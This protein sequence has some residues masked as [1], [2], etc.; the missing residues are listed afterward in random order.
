MTR[1]WSMVLFGQMVHYCYKNDLIRPVRLSRVSLP[2]KKT[3]NSMISITP[4]SGQSRRVLS[5]RRRTGVTSRTLLTS[6]GYEFHETNFL[7]IPGLSILNS[8]SP[9]SFKFHSLDHS[10]DVKP[11]ILKTDEYSDQTSLLGHCRS[12]LLGQ[13]CLPARYEQQT[14]FVTCLLRSTIVE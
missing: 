11:P 2:S 3:R 13:G 8:T 10:P 12:Y 5:E 14:L 6:Y 1:P 9:K 4:D 7:F